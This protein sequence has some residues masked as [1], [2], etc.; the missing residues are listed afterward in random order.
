MMTNSCVVCCHFLALAPEN[1]KNDKPN[2]SS[3]FTPAK[4]HDNDE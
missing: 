2:L 4:K 3:F 1:E